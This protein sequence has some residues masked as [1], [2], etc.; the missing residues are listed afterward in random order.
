LPRLEPARLAF[1]PGGTPRSEA[2]GDLYHSAEGGLAQA[3]HVFLAG[4]GLPERWRSRERFTI[5]ELGFGFGLSFLAAWKAWQ[6]D[7]ARCARLHFASIEK[8]PFQVADLATLHAPHQALAALSAQL[9]DAWPVLVPGL[10]RLEFDQGRVV[11][12][13]ALG[14]VADTLP[15]LELA[16]DAV[17]LDGFAPA[18][19]PEMWT[20]GVMRQLSRLAAPGA[21]AATWSVAAAVRDGLRGAGFVAEKR[22]GFAHKSEMLVANLAPRKRENAPRARL[23]RRAL[24]IGAGVAGAAVCESLARRGWEVTLMER[25]AGPAAEA[26]GNPAGA[27][28][29]VM[30][31]DDSLFARLTRA[32][33]LYA[34][35]HWSKLEGLQ[36]ARCGALQIA[37]DAEEA[38]SQ[39]KSLAALGA[40][41]SYAQLLDAGRAGAVA[42]VEVTAGGIWFPQA[43]WLKPASLVEALLARCGDRLRP[44]YSCAVDSLEREASDWP[45]VILAN[46]TD[47]LRLAPRPEVPLRKVRGQLSVVPAIA[48]L[49]AVLLRGGMALPGVDGL[50][51]IGA[52]Y[53]VD[54]DDP[55]LRA[56][57]HAGN[58]ERLERIIPGASRG[59]DPEKL[60]GRV[61][62]RATVRDRMPLIGPLGDGLFGA[63]AYG[64]RGLLWASLGAELIASTL[65]VEPLPVERTLAAAVDPGRFALRASRRDATT[66][67]V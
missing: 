41:E 66:A 46:A 65:E 10:H 9:R 12:T 17:F 23:E 55:R 58:L 61:A 57:S 64:S 7:P 31:P 56:D 20:P 24:V 38:T 43:G 33:F 40:P 50:S 13:L 6:E 28:H 53:D 27:F 62:F 39:R 52:S 15:Q 37:R 47:A 59:L 11:L 14:D 5:L 44:R 36:W 16:A 45:V 49:N 63:F 48:G 30:T 3:Q 25:N 8:H 4:T 21:I 19:N 26:S 67:P 42:G 35:R 32:A 51:V 22:R 29:P 2:Y 54:D 60:A 1:A 18:K 34:L